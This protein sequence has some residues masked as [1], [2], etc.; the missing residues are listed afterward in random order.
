MEDINKILFP[1]F[2]STI[3]EKLFVGNFVDLVNTFNLQDWKPTM[4]NPK[5]IDTPTEEYTIYCTL[6]WLIEKVE[7]I[8]PSAT[9]TNQYYLT[10]YLDKHLPLIMHMEEVNKYSNTYLLTDYGEGAPIKHLDKEVFHEGMLPDVLN[11]IPSCS[12]FSDNRQKIN[13]VVHLLSKALPQ[14]CT[15]RN[16][17]EI[18]WHWRYYFKFL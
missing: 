1:Y 11:Y 13:P 6:G 9:H 7:E 4:W 5:H 2:V 8:I 10:L 16:L 17:T 12:F 15:I 3:Y 18:L 14:R